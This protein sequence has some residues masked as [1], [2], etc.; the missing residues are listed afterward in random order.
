MIGS[1]L[2]AVVAA[3]AP[4]SAHR[5]DEAV[6][7]TF[8][9]ALVAGNS[10]HLEKNVHVEL[11]YDAEFRARHTP[12]QL[13]TTAHAVIEK[14]KDCDVGAVIRGVGSLNYTV[15]WWCK[16]RDE[17][18]GSPLEG[19]AAVFRVRK[20]LVEVSNFSWQQPYAVW[21]RTSN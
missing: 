13:E 19:A 17:A 11:R 12:G 20:G 2:V 16:Y 21:P 7:R 3:A 8:L 5:D 9:A 6:M 14:T 1:I 4:V 10:D 18:E 15:N